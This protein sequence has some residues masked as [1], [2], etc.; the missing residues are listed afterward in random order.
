MISIKFLNLIVNN[1]DHLSR[2]WCEE[3]RKTEYMKTYQ[4][5]QEDELIKRNKKFF[6]NLAQWVKTGLSRKEIG[7]YF[8]GVGRERY[9][10]KFPL[11]EIH[12]GVFLAKKVI[13][14]MIL[15]EALLDSAVE[16]YQA[17]E[18]VTMVYNFFDTGNFYVTRGYLEAMYADL[19]HSKKFTEKELNQYFPPGSFFHQDL[20]FI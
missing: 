20:H 8:V 13:Y 19:G 15:A 11:S 6:E 3:V 4:K 5:F 9:Q 1:A 18:L 12:Y 17:M 10:E 7:N 2:S 14:N 16:I